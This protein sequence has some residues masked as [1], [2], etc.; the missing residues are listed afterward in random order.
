MVFK[1]GKLS[2]E[3]EKV[4][5]P[6]EGVLVGNPGPGIVHGGVISAVLAAELYLAGK[7][8]G[9]TSVKPFSMAPLKGEE[10]T[11]IFILSAL[12]YN[13][14]RKK[15]TVLIYVHIKEISLCTS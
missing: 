6:M 7:K 13:I 9:S 12:S 4:S 11:R 15:C 3:E 14:L 5:F 2:T 1:V 8:K 10:Q